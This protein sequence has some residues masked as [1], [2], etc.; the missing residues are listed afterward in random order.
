M[1]LFKRLSYSFLAF[2][3]LLPS[4]VS[5]A[6]SVYANEN[7]T[8]TYS[9]SEVSFVGIDGSTLVEVIDSSTVKLTYADGSVDL[10]EKKSDGVYKNGELFLS[11]D[12][13]TQSES[14]L[15]RA[16][17]NSW[18]VIGSSSGR[19]DRDSTLQ[20]LVGF[21]YG[22]ILGAVGGGPL[23]SLVGLLTAAIPS[24]PPGA[25][26]KR[27]V[28]FNEAQMKFKIVTSYYKN[29]DFTGYVTTTTKYLNVPV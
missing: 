22:T 14:P 16:A 9:S 8:D 26:S 10:L 27:T 20:G 5:S 19:S 12:V 7:I 2:I 13:F 4:F 28:Y 24:N 25:Y 1:S 15:S 29:S 17:S 18:R 21:L 3:V 11:N 23:G 6:T